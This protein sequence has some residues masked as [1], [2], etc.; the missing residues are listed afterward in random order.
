ML[1]T[2]AIFS[3]HL[4]IENL[5]KLNLKAKTHATT[6][7]T[8]GPVNTQFYSMKIMSCFLGA[9]K[10][11]TAADAQFIEFKREQ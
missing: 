2:V 5:T 7:P 8:A 1:S 6:S 4:L 9:M 10:Q 11:S 3:M